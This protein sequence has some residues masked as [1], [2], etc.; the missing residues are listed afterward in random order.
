MYVDVILPLSLPH[1]FTYRVPQDMESLVQVGSRVAVQ[2]GKKRKYAAVIRRIHEVEPTH[3]AP[4]TFLFLIDE[5]PI[6][7]ERQLQFWDWLAEYYLAAVGDV[8]N[9]ALPAYLKLGSE[10]VLSYNE[11]FGEEFSGLSD[12]EYMIA[13]ALS[14]RKEL[15]FVEIQ[16]LLGKQNV[17]PEIR[18]LLE[19]KVCFLY[20]EL[21]EHY[22]PKMERFVTLKSGY[23][24]DA[25]LEELFESIKR[26]PKQTEVVLAYLQYSLEGGE[27]RVQDLL[28][29]ASATHQALNALVERQ[30]FEITSKEVDRVGQAVN[31]DDEH[32]SLTEEQQVALQHIQEG[33]GASKTVLLHGVTSSGKTLVYFELI[34]AC[35]RSGKQ[36]LYLLPEIALT[37]QLIRRLQKRFGDQVGIYHSKFSDN[38]RV[39]IWNKIKN[40]TYKAVVGARSALLLPFMDLGLII[41]D[42]EHDASYKQQDPAPRYHA[43]DAAIYYGRLFGAHVLLGSATPSLESFYHAQTGKYALATLTQRFGG[44]Q[45]PE[46]MVADLKEDR[47]KKLSKGNFS[48]ALVDAIGSALDSGEQVI[49]FQNRRGYAPMVQ[50]H[51]CG[52]IAKCRNC[53]VSLTYHKYHHKLHCHYCG[54][55]YPWPEQCHACGSKHL[56]ERNFGTEKIEAELEVLFPHARVARMDMDSVRTKYAHQKLVDLFENKQY[57][58]LVGTQMVVKGLDFDHV[59]LVGILSADQLL[60]YPDFRVHER[61]FQLMEQVSG[62]SGRRQARGKVIIQAVNVAHPII[63]YVV[64]HDY[65]SFYE[66]ELEERRKYNYPPFSRLL[67]LTF[68]HRMR[69]TVSL[70]A[71]EMVGYLKSLHQIDII[72]PAEPPISRIRN[73]YLQ[74]ALIK[75]P[76]GSEGIKRIRLAV[77]QS[78][79]KVWQKKEYRSVVFIPDMDVY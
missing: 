79:D 51:T 78:Y 50:C 63:Q 36:M 55:L 61:A 77:Q 9:A 32:W 27:V 57:D 1:L 54:A 31:K 46:I 11:A 23:R 76:K 13:E 59:N 3:Y 70:C 71:E 62:R 68:K 10:T 22:R 8:M 25:R 66:Q 74:E 49:L 17:F 72:G 75:L 48:S 38:E 7:Y 4:K 56:Q 33:F 19:L 20:E 15:S 43:R 42:E 47:F 40:G 45:M 35:I 53:D 64:H 73:Q 6:V 44:I 67:K 21:K 26:A 60:N 16:K 37:T 52:W 29:R 39:E 28:K 58:I 41:L 14:I 30:V 34:D 65:A 24:E 69:N 5:E 12:A 2:F 18:A